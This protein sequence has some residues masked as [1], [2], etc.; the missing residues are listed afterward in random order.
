MQL[1]QRFHKGPRKME[2]VELEAVE[3]VMTEARCWRNMR[4]VS[5]AREHW[6]P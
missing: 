1:A 3:D 4:K 5:Q 6:Q 2:A